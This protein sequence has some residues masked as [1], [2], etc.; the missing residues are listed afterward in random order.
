[1]SS[2]LSKKKDEKSYEERLET[3]PKETRRNKM[4][5]KKVFADFVKE[6]YDRTTPEVIQE[7]QLLKNSKNSESYEDALYGML[8]D[9]IN[10]SEKIGRGNY[11]IRTTFSNLR[12]YLF[13][14]G[15]KTHDQD[16]KEHLRF[17]K[18]KRE[19][20]HPLSQKVYRQIILGHARNPRYQ[21][22]F[23]VLG[24]S[25]MRIGEAINLRKKDLDVNSKRI[26]VT[27]ND[28]KTSLGRTTYVSNE[29]KEYLTPLLEKLNPEDYIFAR[30]GQKIHAQSVRHSLN[31]L[32]DRLGINDKYQINRYRKITSHSFRAYF[33]TK[34]ARKH[35][36]NYAHK[37]VGHGG[38][39]MQ[40]DR[41]TE[42]EKL[43]MYIELEP[44]LV[45]FDQ[46]KNELEI[47]KLQKENETIGELREMVKRLQQSQAEYDKK[48]LETF[49]KNGSIP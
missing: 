9:W 23:L 24:S 16:I 44:E 49:R 26:K 13:H 29:A 33:F 37:I 39:L 2:F 5:A 40:Y 6:Q 18:R 4:Y 8:Q 36:D 22:L 47:E 1:M 14:L 38:Y 45:V 17:G 21:A 35:G 27:I 3:L 32:L 7:L 10:W 19:E 41:M 34:A 46:A 11:T 48:L 15:I 20:K 43:G 28:S 31:R 42:E 30:K 12:K 25:G